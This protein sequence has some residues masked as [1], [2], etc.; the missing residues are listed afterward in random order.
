MQ[1]ARLVHGWT[2]KQTARA[3]GVSQSHI[4]RVEQGSTAT[5]TRELVSFY[6]ETFEQD[7]LLTSL[8]EIVISTP[9]QLRRKTHGKP[10]RTLRAIEGDAS[11]F[12]SDTIP[13]GSL[14]RPGA[15]FP[16][17]WEIQNS[18]TVAWVDRYLER[19]GPITGPGLIT[20]P[21]L[22]RIPDTLPGAT[23]RID[24]ILKAPTYDCTS[25]AYFKMVDRGLNLCFPDTY[26]LG[27]EVLVRVEGQLPDK[28]PAPEQDWHQE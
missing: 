16:K 21:R 19:Q 27:L 28:E 22:V 3:F 14:M 26:Q 8:Y 17:T 6:D 7:G 20:S 1:K 13:N 12:L 4:T 18:G 5:P 11:T 2:G 23:A 24:A 10:R 15:V 25:I 9:E